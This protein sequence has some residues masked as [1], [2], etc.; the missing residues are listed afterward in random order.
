MS[1]A[2][3][4]YGAIAHG[5]ALGRALAAFGR[6]H[7]M[8]AALTWSLRL[9]ALG[10]ALDVALLAAR[11]FWPA[12]DPPSALLLLPPLIGLLVGV[13][14]GMGRRPSALWLAREI[15]ARLNLRE[16][17][18][19]ALELI[20]AQRDA[21]T[22]GRGL[23]GAEPGSGSP[24]HQA[25]VQAAEM[26]RRAKQAAVQ[27]AAMARQGNLPPRKNAP[28]SSSRAMPTGGVAYSP[29]ASEQ[30]LA[31]AQLEDAVH[32]LRRADPLDAFPLRLP[33]REAFAA[34]LLALLL[35]PLL[36]L[37]PPRAGSAQGTSAER[38]ALGEAERLEAVADEIEADQLMEQDGES[39]AQLAEMLREVAEGVRQAATDPD[40]AVAQL[41]DAER[42]MA[43]LQR[44]QAFDTAA[45]LARMADALDRDQRTRPVSNALDRRDYRR[46]A[47]EMRQLGQQAQSGS[48]ADRQA[49]SEAL[50]RAAAATARYDERMA[51]ALRQ[52]AEQ[53]SRGEQGATDGAAQQ[54]ERAGGEMR[55]QETLERALSQLQNSRQSVASGT[56]QDG[57]RSESRA[58]NRAGSEPGQGEGEGQGQGAGQR[59]Q[60]EGEG[61]GQ[62]DGQGQGQGDGEGQGG[63]GAGTG[64]GR[65]G[66]NVYDPAATRLRQVQV[67]GGDFD[68]PQVTE[69]DQQTDDAQ[70]EVTVDY[71]DVLPTYQE[72]AT[73]AMQDRYVPLGMKDLV[74]EYFSSLGER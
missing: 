7:R 36:L 15:D 51:D 59:G 67:P 62:G 14:L 3:R 30:A 32:H 49:I 5:Q 13:A 65:G 47:E 21:G 10:L 12:V 34:L 73:R 38:L 20:T 61:S 46:A 42:R 53:A 68:R 70:G 50:Q 71:R 8:Q 33:R 39:G 23:A 74:R 25:A 11:R 66:T 22:P 16:R 27:A 6:A 56:R 48:Q 37:A 9:L 4:H 29:S 58:G 19:T 60:G 57:A 55:R 52:A 40:R 31:Q 24:R 18:L 1:V 41:G 54:M 35:V 63:S 45:A 43:Q 64:G 26:A 2:A 44:P 17:T 28:A 72:R 69:G